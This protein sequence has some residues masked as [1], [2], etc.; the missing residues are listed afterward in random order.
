M[1]L[2]GWDAIS[3]NKSISVCHI[4]PLI[5]PPL[6]SSVCEEK[7]ASMLWLKIMCLSRQCASIGM[8]WHLCVCVCLV[9]GSIKIYVSLSFG[10]LQHHLTIAGNYKQ[11]TCMNACRRRLD[12]LFASFKISRFLLV[13]M[14]IFSLP[15]ASYAIK[16]S[17]R[18]KIWDIIEETVKEVSSVKRK[19]IILCL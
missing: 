10:L 17:V 6:T 18:I 4:F 3:L 14:H 16:F 5:R 19:T 12:C 1:E 9:G 15:F 2:M 11:D 8:E 13:L 7:D